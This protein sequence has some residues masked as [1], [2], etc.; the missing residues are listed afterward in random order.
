M[1]FNARNLSVLAYAN[2]FTL[3]HYLAI[4]STSHEVCAS[5]YFN[6]AAGGLHDGDMI[7]VAGPDYGFIRRVAPWDG[8]NV[9]TAA[10]Q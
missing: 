5:G 4:K 10:V 9:T 6:G 7:L 8:E 3:H 2:G 1:P